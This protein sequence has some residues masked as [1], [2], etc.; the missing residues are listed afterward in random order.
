M[1][2]KIFLIIPLLILLT[3]CTVNYDLIID[4]NSLKETIT[5]DVEKKEYEVTENDTSPNLFYTLIN[6]DTPALIDESGLYTKSIKENDKGLDYNYTYTYKNNLSES[7]VLNSCFENHEIN[8]TDDY[9]YIKLSGEFYCLYTDK[10]NINV[11][12]NYEVME[13][14]AKKIDGN[15]YT[16]IID[17][18]N[19]TNITL[20]VSKTVQY[21]EPVKAKTFSTFQIIGFIVFAILTIIT[22]FL[23]KKKNSGR[24]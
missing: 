1:K 10:I 9:Y 24:V 3:G 8:E 14:N 22:Y 2:N 6:G 18:S 19:N 4:N 13:S 12:S 7:R 5:G 11:T 16:W 23:Y 21:E 20:T 15:K 17:N